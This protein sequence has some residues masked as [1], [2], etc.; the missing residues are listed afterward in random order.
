MAH[1]RRPEALAETAAE[2]ARLYPTLSY[3]LSV[4]DDGSPFVGPLVGPV[5]L[6]RL[7]AKQRPLNP[8]VPINRA[9][10]ASKGEII[11]LT[12]PEMEHRVPL[13]PAMLALLEQPLDYVIAPARDIER[14]LWL[15]GPEVDYTTG[16]RQAVPPGGHFHFLVAFRRTL[17]EQAGGFDEDYRHGQGCDDNDWLWRVYAA[18]ARFRVA[19]VVVWHH[20]SRLS[21]NLPLN[22]DLFLR[23]WP[24]A[25]RAELERRVA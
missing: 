11:V 1:W 16:G 22:R 10:A 14:H 17:W 13:L 3:E 8:C 15:A 18:G 21:W 25:R 9:V 19:P 4:C 2:Y 20:D 7:P 6:T 23:K 12:N 5:T 24:A